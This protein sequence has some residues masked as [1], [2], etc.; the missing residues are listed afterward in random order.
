MGS[1]RR[2]PLIEGLLRP[3]T[4]A[5]LALAEWDRLLPRARL[6]EL[7]PRLAIAAQREGILDRLP[8]P[9]TKHLTTGLALAGAQRRVAEW[10]LHCLERELAPLG[11]PVMLLKGAAYVAARLGGTFERRAV[12]ALWAA[13]FGPSRA[14]RYAGAF[15]G[16]VILLFGARLAGGCTSGHGIS[17]ALQLALSSWTFVAAML[18]SGILTARVLFH[19]TEA[20]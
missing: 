9:V 5:S 11:A 10:E 17:G 1:F 16:G 18:A 2:D 4:M 8:E 7:L 13:R 14:K 12:P 3:K 20:L 19:R 15:L 6:A